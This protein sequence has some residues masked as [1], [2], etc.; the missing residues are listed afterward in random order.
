LRIDS[1]FVVIHYVNILTNRF[2]IPLIVFENFP[3]SCLGYLGK[4]WNLRPNLNDVNVQASRWQNFD[5]ELTFCVSA[6]ID[7][8]NFAVNVALS[9]KPGC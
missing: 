8:I 4:K 1:N 3:G 9:Q 2:Q 5:L 7:P 6:H